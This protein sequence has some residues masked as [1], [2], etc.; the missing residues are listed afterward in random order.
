VLKY[1]A[2]NDYKNYRPISI[3]S[4][5]SKLLEKIISNEIIAHLKSTGQIPVNQHDFLPRRLSNTLH[6]KTINDWHKSLDSGGHIHVISLDWE[7]AFDKIPH[8]RLLLKLRN[9]GI[10]GSI[11]EWFKCYLNNRKQRVLC[12][13]TFS[14]TLD[15]PSGVIQGSVTFL[16]HY[17][18]TS[19]FRICLNVSPLTS[20]CMQMTLLYTV[21][22]K[23]SMIC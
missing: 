5:I 7:K 10:S 1:G 19:L 9:A 6:M 4:I 17:F 14:D 18:S 11:F 15:V 3:T 8:Q 23:H 12:S 21:T 2:R 22:L 13:G 20:L 16:V